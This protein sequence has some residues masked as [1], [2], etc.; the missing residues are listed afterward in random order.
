MSDKETFFNKEMSVMI[1][2]VAIIMMLILHLFRFPTWYLPGVSWNSAL[3]DIGNV[4]TLTLS[5]FGGICVSLYA[6]MNGY[7][8]YIYPQSHNTLRIRF[9]RL[10]K[11]LTA[12]WLACILFIIYGYALNEPLPGI[13]DF[14][15]NLVGIETGPINKYINVSFGWYVTSIVR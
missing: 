11:F 8:L 4:I 15:L 9:L 2:G 13:Q 6:M 5:K 14:V 7:S 10:L 3:G 1:S 12:Y